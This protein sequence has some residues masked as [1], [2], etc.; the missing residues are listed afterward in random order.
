MTE[1]FV[2]GVVGSSYG[3]RGHVKVHV[4]SGET[5]HLRALKKVELRLGGTRRIYEVQ[6]TAHAASSFVMKF[7]G[8]DSPEVAQTLRGAEL[9]ADRDHAAPLGKDEFY[10][11]DLKGLSVLLAEAGNERIGEILDVLEGGGGQL[12]EITLDESQGGGRRL[13]PFRDEFF[14]RIDTAARTAV[15]RERWMLG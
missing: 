10:I 3:V 4:P 9:V 7:R 5:S 11:E 14:G 6:E 13:V 8:I 12:V 1:L 2:I 15:L